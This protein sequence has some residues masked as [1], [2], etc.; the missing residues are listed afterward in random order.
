MRFSQISMLCFAAYTPHTPLLIDSIG[1]ENK[2]QILQTHKAMQELSDELY[3]SFPDVI[4]VISSHSIIHTQAFS[5]NLHETYE[6][7]LKEFGDLK[8]Y[9]TFLPDLELITLIQREARV[10]E[11]PFILTSEKTLEYA[12]GVP[13]LLLCQD[14]LHPRI[15]PVS[16]SG[17][18]RKSHLAF[19]RL[20]KEVIK[21]SPKRIAVVASGDL[22]HCLSSE[23][24][25][26][27]RKEGELFD[28]MILHAT[29]QLSTSTLL[30][31][32]EA[33]LE[34]AAQCGFRPLLILFGL[35]ERV[36]IRPEIRS[37]ESPFGVGYLVAQFHL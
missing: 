37:Y 3:A 19:G 2:K 7:S 35:L 31:F 8:T 13:L 36:N 9:T 15:V 12:A 30:S 23:A 5:A 25:M 11:I 26:G 28:Q 21:N 27:F 29:Q 4:L 10:Q 6:L 34:Q 18:D 33:V 17:D 24:P 14:R 20:L 16:Y 32:D 22:A 1:K